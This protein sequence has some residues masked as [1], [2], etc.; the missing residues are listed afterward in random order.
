MLLVKK[1]QNKLFFGGEGH[2]LELRR[3]L[4]GLTYTL[5]RFF[6]YYP[7]RSPPIMRY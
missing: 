1:V 4:F 3:S 2:I 5:S 6:T 7:V